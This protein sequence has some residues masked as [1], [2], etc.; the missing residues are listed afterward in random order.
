MVYVGS[1]SRIA[2]EITSLIIKKILSRG[3]NW[4]YFEPFCGG[5][6]LSEVLLPNFDFIESNL[7]DRNDYLVSLLKYALDPSNER[8]SYEPPTR[9]EWESSRLSSKLLF[10]GLSLKDKALIGAHGLF[11]GFKGIFFGGYYPIDKKS[12]RN[13]YKERLNSFYSTINR[14]RDSKSIVNFNFGGYS[15]QSGLIQ[16]SL[17]RGDVL[18]YCDPPYANECSYFYSEKWSAMS[19]FD[20]WRW[21]TELSLRGVYVL[22]SETS[23]FGGFN[24]EWDCIGEFPIIYTIGGRDSSSKIDR[25]FL[26]KSLGISK[27]KNFKF[28]L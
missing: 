16:S 3:R 1:K 26:H 15:D 21:A 22:V 8:I 4:D 7:S 25:L 12:G 10:M 14:L 13:L 19:H 5:C 9:E 11:C 24:S 20:F 17:D 18:V 27:S 28:E 6:G 23:V 2:N